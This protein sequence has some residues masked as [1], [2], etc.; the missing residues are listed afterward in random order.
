[1]EPGLGQ[2]SHCSW[3][4]PRE[5]IDQPEGREVGAPVRDGVCGVKVWGEGQ[6]PVGI[7]GLKN[8]GPYHPL[9]PEA[10]LGS[11]SPFLSR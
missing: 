4:P 8:P 7:L 6:F 5:V 3:A 10:P 1:M 11:G 2:G 9:R